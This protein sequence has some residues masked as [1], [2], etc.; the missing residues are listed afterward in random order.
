MLA[1]NPSLL[2]RVYTNGCFQDLYS[3]LLYEHFPCNFHTKIA[4]EYFTQFE[5]RVFFPF[6]VTSAASTGM[7]TI[8]ISD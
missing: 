5:I 1:L 4:S 7:S 8:K 2:N 3:H 6:N